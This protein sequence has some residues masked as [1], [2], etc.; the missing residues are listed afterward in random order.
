MKGKSIIGGDTIVPETTDLEFVFE[1]SPENDPVVHLQSQL[2]N[3]AEANEMAVAHIEQQ[4][5]NTW[6]ELED[7]FM[8]A[9][10]ER[11]GHDDLME[12]AYLDHR[13]R[14]R[15]V[16]SADRQRKRTLE[17]R[18]MTKMLGMA[19]EMKN[20]FDI[21]LKHK[22]DLAREKIRHV[23]SESQAHEEK[24]TET[25][26]AAA[27]AQ[28]SNEHARYQSI[29]QDLRENEEVR[30]QAMEKALREELDFQYQETIE[31]LEKQERDLLGS[32]GGL[33]NEV[34]ELKRR[35]A[36]LMQERATQA[37]IEHSL[38]TENHKLKSTV[39]E[40]SINIDDLRE[41]F[42][43]QSVT[44]TSLLDALNLMRSH[45]GLRKV[46]VNEA[47]G[48]DLN[49]YKDLDAIT[50]L[51]QLL[52][53]KTERIL[54]LKENTDALT[55]Q[56]GTSQTENAELRKEIEALRT[57]A[58]KARK[59][60]TQAQVQLSKLKDASLNTPRKKPPVRK[61]KKT[62]KA[63]D[64]SSGNELSDGGSSTAAESAA[65]L[66]ARSTGKRKPYT[67]PPR[68][69]RDAKPVSSLLSRQVGPPPQKTAPLRAA[70]RPPTPPTQPASLPD[71]DEDEAAPPRPFPKR[72]LKS[73][74]PS[75]GREI[76]PG[77]GRGMRG[78]GIGLGPGSGLRGMDE[79]RPGPF[80]WLGKG[81]NQGMAKKLAD[82]PSSNLRSV[83]P[84]R[85]PLPVVEEPPSPGSPPEQSAL[86]P[87]TGDL[88]LSELMKKTSL[89]E[90]RLKRMRVAW[91]EETKKTQAAGANERGS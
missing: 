71:E 54:Q 7:M 74:E 62:K 78:G 18:V 83:S 70:V 86:N 21:D 60:A 1:A 23:K 46:T 82:M 51:E 34:E 32:V 19:F 49:D 56:L 48:G 52:Q 10:R 75:L 6:S 25:V 24:T 64:S 45:Y 28:V 63:G 15:Q 43:R 84:M 31:K 40:L 53:E 12:G 8:A 42:K 26:R 73:S 66:S 50:N 76:T 13:Q 5:M 79:V 61:K 87:L 38:T 35:I 69:P 3:L 16:V 80:D 57:Q 11:Y 2:R 44:L 58:N 72:E 22:T 65:M 85:E 36:Q 59:Q 37:T 17:K 77:F 41:E 4:F 27:R 67:S 39:G 9:I 14:L 68:S 81:E 88:G 89:L 29:I 20:L 47:V 91:E 55:A 33:R 30:R 90:E